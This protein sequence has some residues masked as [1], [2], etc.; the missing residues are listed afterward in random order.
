MENKK[1]IKIMNSNEKVT[2]EEFKEFIW[3]EML[4]VAN[5]LYRRGV[6]HLNVRYL[7]KPV[8]TSIISIKNE[9]Q[10]SLYHWIVQYHNESTKKRFAKEKFNW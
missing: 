2:M 1:V 4:K 9:E 8:K 7:G 6:T 5:Y 10:S 3:P